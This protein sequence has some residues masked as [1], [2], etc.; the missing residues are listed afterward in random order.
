MSG[1]I[2]MIQ[3]RR[4]LAFEACHPP[5]ILLERR[6][7]YLNHH[8]PPELRI[9]RAIDI[10]HT[11]L[12]G[13]TGGAV[14]ADGSPGAHLLSPSHPGHATIFL[15]DPA[16]G[17]RRGDGLWVWWTNA[18]GNQRK[19]RAG[20]RRWQRNR[21]RS[22]PGAALGWLFGGARRTPP[23]GARKNRRPVERFWRENARRAH[24]RQLT[25][26]RQRAVR[27]NQAGV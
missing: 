3:R 10:A 22:V 7:H 6:R 24:R 18:H 1:N 4:R 21:A 17:G 9:G 16:R 13:L 15:S 23:R 20:N 11:V 27:Q 19:D 14:L 12:A 8:L 26:V 25:R 2:R 5:G